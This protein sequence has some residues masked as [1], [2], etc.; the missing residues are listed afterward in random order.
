MAKTSFLLTV[1]FVIIAFGA[2]AQKDRYMVFFKDKIETPHQ[3]QQSIRH[4]L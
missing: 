3:E 1:L 2:I 4:R